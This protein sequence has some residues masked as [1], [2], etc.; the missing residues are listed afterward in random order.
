[1]WYLVPIVLAPLVHV[2]KVLVG[3][4]FDFNPI[5]SCL[6]S[7]ISTS[8]LA[9]DSSCQVRGNSPLGNGSATFPCL[10]TLSS[11]TICRFPTMRPPW[12][13]KHLP[14]RFPLFLPLAWPVPGWYLGPEMHHYGCYTVWLRPT[15][16][17][18]ITKTL[19]WLPGKVPLL[20]LTAVK[21]I[22]LSA[23]DVAEALQ[24]PADPTAT[25]LLPMH[26]APSLTFSPTMQ[27]P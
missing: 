19:A 8:T 4:E 17:V 26:S 3:V 5:L 24:A 7:P 23:L 25:A 1:M 15:C 22:Y 27:P 13:P 9:S 2:W 11:M 21:R 10:R 14:A 6:T 12:S 16:A 18:C 20:V